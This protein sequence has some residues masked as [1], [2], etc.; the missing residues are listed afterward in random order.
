[1]SNLS[2]II[3]LD[4]L[5]GFPPNTPEVIDS[6]IEMLSVVAMGSGQS[7]SEDCKGSMATIINRP[8]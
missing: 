2:L 7:W 3:F 6:A 4:P 1:L 5:Y 8:N